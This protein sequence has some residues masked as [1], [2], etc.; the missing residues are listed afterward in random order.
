MN[1]IPDRSNQW[2]EVQQ[3]LGQVHVA[4]QSGDLPRPQPGQALLQI[5]ACGICAADIRVVS[6]DK[7]S[8]GESDRYTVL[9]H[10][11]VG[12]IIAVNED[13]ARFQP[14]DY[15]VILPHVHITTDHCDGPRCLTSRINPVCT[16]SG[17]TLHMGW[18]ID[19]C[20]AD[21]VLVPTSNMVHVAPKHLHRASEQAPGL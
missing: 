11:G 14:G 20:F 9:G 13:A 18:D 4:R 16:G 15:V 1:K 5:V 19:G 7:A 8:S 17:H 21:F 3:H 2:F 10:E 12:R 6:G